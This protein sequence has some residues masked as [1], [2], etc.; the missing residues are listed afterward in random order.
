MDI[1][2]E[3]RRLQTDEARRSEEMRVL[4][5]VGISNVDS[6]DIEENLGLEYIFSAFACS[7]GCRISG[8]T[9]ARLHEYTVKVLD[10][11]GVFARCED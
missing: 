3:L 5:P 2:S 10:F 8:R 7:E 4:A 11:G 6:E 1:V 9:Y